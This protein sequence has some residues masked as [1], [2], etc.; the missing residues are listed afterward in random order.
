MKVQVNGGAGFDSDVDLNPRGLH[1]NSG[2]AQW[3]NETLVAIE[4]LNTGK[5]RVVELPAR[6]TNLH[7]TRRRFTNVGRAETYIAEEWF[8]R[9]IVVQCKDVFDELERRIAAF[10]EQ[11]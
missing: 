1:E 10:V 8:D 11:G 3:Q 7:T 2:V 5:Y 6:T 9:C 4:A